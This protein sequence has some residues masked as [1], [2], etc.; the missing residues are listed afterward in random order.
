MERRTFIPAVFAGIFLQL[1]TS[2][3]AYHCAGISL[4][5][6]GLELVC[7]SSPPSTADP[8]F[9]V[10]VMTSPI[11]GSPPVTGMGRRSPMTACIPVS[12]AIRLPFFVYPY[13]SG[14]G[15]LRPDD[16]RNRGAYFYINLCG[17]LERGCGHNHKEAQQ[18]D[19]IFFHTAKMSSLR[20]RFVTRL[21][22]ALISFT[23]SKKRPSQEEEDPFK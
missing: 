5:G 4:I 15:L 16:Y 11:A 20:H 23:H 7:L 1:H 6:A 12:T 13:V 19:E 3:T 9:S 8:L 22:A 10:T 21:V 17:S 14:G 18:S 2:A